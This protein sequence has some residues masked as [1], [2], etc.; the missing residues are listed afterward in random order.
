MTC[1]VTEEDEEKMDH[2]ALLVR[3]DLQEK[4]YMNINCITNT[5]QIYIR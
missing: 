2:L 5:L 1:R 3:L 4:K